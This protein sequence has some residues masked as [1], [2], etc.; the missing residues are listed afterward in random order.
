MNHEVFYAYFPHL[1]FVGLLSERDVLIVLIRL[2][3]IYPTIWWRE[4]T[5]SDGGRRFLSIHILC[6]DTDRCKLALTQT[7][8]Q[9]T[10]GADGSRG[11]ERSGK[12]LLS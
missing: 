3:P 5:P 4:G 7:L 9:T 10:P 2:V 11:G 12:Q 8:T 6:G 1:P